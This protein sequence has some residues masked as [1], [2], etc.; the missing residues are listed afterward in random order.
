M[1]KNND[2]HVCIVAYHMIP[3]TRIWGASQRMYYLAN[4][5]VD[6]G[7]DTTVISGFYGEFKHEGKYSNFEHIPVL[8]KPK[9]IQNHQ[10]KLILK[11]IN[12][13]QRGLTPN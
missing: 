11:G 10:E 7:F 6:S 5:L 1:N 13:E 3:Y 12:I 2:C 4:Q 9:F 8:T